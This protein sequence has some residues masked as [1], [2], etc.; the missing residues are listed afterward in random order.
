M[1]TVD[2]KRWSCLTRLMLKISSYLFQLDLPVQTEKALESGRKLQVQLDGNIA[3][4]TL[5]RKLKVKSLAALRKTLQ[6]MPQRLLMYSNISTAL[7]YLLKEKIT[8]K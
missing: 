2:W 5:E 7:L 6:K 4:A 3:T 8:L 1:L